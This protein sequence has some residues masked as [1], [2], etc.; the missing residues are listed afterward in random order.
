MV[1]GYAM[2]KDATTLASRE[3]LEK[4]ERVTQHATLDWM[5]KLDEM[6]TKAEV[7]GLYAEALRNQAPKQVLDAITAK[8]KT[9]K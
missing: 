6:D 2:N 9:A 5:A 8:G 4:V 1:A 3:E 7:R